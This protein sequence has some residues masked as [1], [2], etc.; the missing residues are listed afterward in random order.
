ML[1]SRDIS[2]LR[3]DVETNCRRL[4]ELCEAE[5]LPVLITGTVRDEE[6]QLQCYNNGYSKAKVPSFHSVKAGLA[7][8]LCKNVKGQEYGDAAF[9]AKVAT[10]AKSIGFSWGGDWTSIVDKPHFQWDANG[11][12]NSSMIIA[13]NYPPLMPAY[14]GDDEMFAPSTLTEEQVYSLWSK[15]MEPLKDNDAATWS[16]EARQFALAN[17]IIVGNGSGNYQWEKPLTREEM[18]VMLYRFAKHLKAIK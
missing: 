1:N 16:E 18:A 5:G 8:D 17:G 7:F 13:G 12:Y 15:L 4:L 9:F 14:E 10:L 11:S 3:D 2:L 6:Y